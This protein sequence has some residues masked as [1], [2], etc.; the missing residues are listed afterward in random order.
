MKAVILARVSTKGKGQTADQQEEVL[1]E[2]AKK[3]GYEVVEVIRLEQSAYKQESAAKVEA[4]VF[5]PF[6]EGRAD[7]LMVWAMDRWTRRGPQAALRLIHD[8]ENHYNAHFFSLQESFLSTATMDPLVRELMLSL[9]GWMAKQESARKSERILAKVEHKKQAAA[10]LGQRAKWA[11]GK[12]LLEAEK[13]Q[14]RALKGKLSQRKLA[15]KF[16]TS[17]GTINKV[18]NEQ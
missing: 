11:G 12:M 2:Q 13:E 10:K 14:I 17:V 8:L 7:V 18:L 16:N 15:E 4:M 9:M 5:E 1:R 6:K 3:A